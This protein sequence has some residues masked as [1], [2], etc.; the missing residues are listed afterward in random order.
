MNGAIGPNRDC[1]MMKENGTQKRT[2]VVGNRSTPLPYK[3]RARVVAG[4]AGPISLCDSEAE[5]E[6]IHSQSQI[7]VHVMST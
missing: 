6:G 3:F 1:H 7:V 5:T 4:K 2:K